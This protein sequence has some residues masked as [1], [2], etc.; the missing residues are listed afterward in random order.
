RSRRVKADALQSDD[1]S[2]VCDPQ[3]RNAPRT[4]VASVIAREQNWKTV[5]VLTQNG[6]TRPSSPERLG[7][8]SSHR[9]PRPVILRLV[10]NLPV[11][12]PDGKDPACW[13]RNVAN[14]RGPAGSYWR[15]QINPRQPDLRTI[16]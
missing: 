7:I 4:Q 3:H 2:G 10:M 8:G 13:Q 9:G 11:S 15:T 5:F 1:A 14:L 12:L 6:C 16:N